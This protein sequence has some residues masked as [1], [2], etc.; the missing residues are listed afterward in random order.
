MFK[1]GFLNCLRVNFWG[2]ISAI[3][4][5]I[6]FAFV[7]FPF[8]M[9][10]KFVNT[11]FNALLFNSSNMKLIIG[12]SL[13]LQLV[14]IAFR[15]K[16]WR[17][18]EKYFD[19][20][21]KGFVSL[22]PI[23]SIIIF[24]ILST[25]LIKLFETQYNTVLLVIGK[26]LL[27]FLLNLCV[28]LIIW[29][30]RNLIDQLSSKVSSNQSPIQINEQSKNILTDNPI[31]SPSED[32]LDRKKFVEDI[33]EEI[34]NFPSDSSFVFGLY[35]GW[36]EGKTSFLNLLKQK[37]ENND[38]FLM[39]DFDP[40]YFKDK[41][42]TL[43]AFYNGL[44]H[45]FSEKFV[46]PGFSK[47][48]KKYL[49][50]ISFGTNVGISLSLS[51]ANESAEEM[52]QRIESYLEKTNKKLL[53]VIDD[54]DR[55]QANEILQIFSMV[56]CNADLKN[57]I[58]VLSFDPLVIEKLLQKDLNSDRQYLEKI[59]Q[60]PINLPAIPS[61]NIS[62]FLINNINELFK[63]INIPDDKKENFYN[64]FLPTYSAYISKIFRTL[65][66]VKRYI[67]G[68]SATLPAIKSEVNL[69][70]FFILEAI[71]VFYPSIYNDIWN[72]RRFYIRVGWEEDPT[73][74][75]NKKEEINSAIKEHI[76]STLK[77]AVGEDKKQ[78]EIL[79]ELL[80]ILFPV[81]VKNAFEQG[82]KDY[83]YYM[84]T[85]RAGQRLT[86]P[87][88][89][90]KYFMLKVPP[91]ELSD[92]RIEEII[93]TWNTSKEEE[94][95]KNIEG[96]FFTLQK[97]KALKEFFSKLRIFMN[98]ID[99]DLAVR[100]IRAIYS[101]A[102]KFSKEGTKD[103]LDSEYYKALFLSLWL[104]NDKIDKGEIQSML[105]EIINL[106]SSIPFAVEVVLRCNKERNGSLYNIYESIDFEKLVDVISGRLKKHFIDEKRDIF[107]E[108]PEESDWAIVLYQWGSDWMAFKGKNKDA[109]SSYIVSLVKGNPKKFAKFL[110]H[111]RRRTQ[112]DT[113]A[114][115]LNEFSQV[116]NIKEIANLA[117]K[118][119]SNSDLSDEEKKV[120]EQFLELYRSKPPAS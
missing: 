76:E 17:F 100:I 79:L 82:N 27:L 57:S 41:E 97:S 14:F 83:T 11:F 106:T 52:K 37:F 111:Q 8:L 108:L 107:T 56:K 109:V 113:M 71:R 29:S 45:T 25:G 22:E 33:Y 68:L 18:I 81:K 51:N 78:G 66:H 40:W 120:L 95:D 50:Y 90:I 15:E 55:L 16:V 10:L 26:C 102:D 93:N 64:E 88:C 73:Q 77:E 3:F 5:S 92:E 54:I 19:S 61:E 60:M 112:N 28:A 74:L 48:V 6:T 85:F 65:R 105:E 75:I 101:N 46:L 87:E 84:D 115:D 94:K 67:N 119:K 70:D 42:S 98:K 89:F 58:F 116:Y 72:N 2:I 91:S 24:I 20:I 21:K 96:I 80:K 59:V 118:F 63:R 36:G 117:E 38:N 99:K 86:H 30:T 69:N 104:V 31:V 39:F 23:I 103:F 35:G 32:S 13:I 44:E 49:H 12:L 53:V 1:S 114:F 4:A 47:A 34:V 43:K 110:I 62:N 9:N 7:I